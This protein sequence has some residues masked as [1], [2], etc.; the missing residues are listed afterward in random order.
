[1]IKC[2][3]LTPKTIYSYIDDLVITNFLIDARIGCPCLIQISFAI[4]L[5]EHV[6]MHVLFI[7]GHMF[8]VLFVLVFLGKWMYRM[9]KHLL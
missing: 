6:G 2:S 9:P 4:L 1:M 5:C 7:Q 3:N 8:V